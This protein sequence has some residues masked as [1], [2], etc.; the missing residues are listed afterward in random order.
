MI[1]LKKMV[2]KDKKLYES[3]GIYVLHSLY[4]Q[5]LGCHVLMC[6]LKELTSCNSYSVQNSIFSVLSL[7]NSQ[8]RDRQF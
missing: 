2:K 8:T 3:N 5:F 1:K 4:G 7:T 6:V